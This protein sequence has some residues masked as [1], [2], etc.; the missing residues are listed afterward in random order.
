MCTQ[1]PPGRHRLPGAKL[2][3]LFGPTGEREVGIFY[4]KIQ[5]ITWIHC[6]VS[7]FN[8]CIRTYCIQ[9]LVFL[10]HLHCSLGVYSERQDATSPTGP[11]A[12]HLRQGEQRGSWGGALG[13]H[14]AGT[15]QATLPRKGEGQHSDRPSGRRTSSS[16]EF[17]THSPLTLPG[18]HWFA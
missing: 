12:A 3:L 16:A 9:G 10:P 5:T 14:W 6:M 15:G 4:E 18:F 1:K 7:D 8:C 11:D 17:C 13:R 2:W